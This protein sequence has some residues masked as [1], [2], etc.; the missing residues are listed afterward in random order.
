M[1]S[2]SYDH[3]PPTSKRIRVCVANNENTKVLISMLRVLVCDEKELRTIVFQQELLFGEEGCPGYV[4]RELRGISAS[5]PSI[6]HHTCYRT[7]WNIRHL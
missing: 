3:S 7:C 5:G 2:V 6:S 1:R 4:A